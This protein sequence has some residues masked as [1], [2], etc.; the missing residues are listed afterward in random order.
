MDKVVIHIDEEFSTLMPLLAPEALAELEQS[1]RT[2][3]CRDPLV[4]WDCNG[5]LILLDGHNRLVICQVND[6]PYQTIIKTMEEIPD[7]DA[8]M[9]WIDRTQLARRNLTPDQFTMVL[10]R[11][12][13]RLKRQGARTDRTSGQNDQKSEQAT[14]GET[15]AE[16]LAREHGVSEATVRRAGRRAA[17]KTKPK[18]KKTTPASSPGTE[19]VEVPRDADGREIPPHLIDVFGTQEQ[20]DRFA[21]ILSTLKGQVKQAVEANPIAWS[22]FNE[23][24]FRATI[25]KAHDLLRLS[26]PFIVCPYCGGSE[27]DK[28]RMCKSIGFLDELQAHSVPKEMRP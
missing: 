19:Q 16:R 3:G 11:L 13:N 27:S 22:R 20:F 24:S 5:K 2:E 15:T 25:T 7:R 6:I 23:N 10:G 18:K 12:Y 28:C 9:D 4:A 8:A 26:A 21:Q 14:K 17:G 1:I